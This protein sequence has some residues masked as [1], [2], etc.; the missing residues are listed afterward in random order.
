MA[1]N[2]PLPALK[3]KGLRTNDDLDLLRMI[4]DENPDLKKKVIR[5]MQKNYAKAVA[6]AKV[7]ATMNR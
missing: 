3:K 7:A 2:E 5:F 4:L 6:A 1:K